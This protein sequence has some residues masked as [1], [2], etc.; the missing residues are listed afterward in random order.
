[1]EFGLSPVQRDVQS[2]ARLS[3][4]PASGMGDSGC[5]AGFEKAF[6]VRN[7]KVILNVLHGYPPNNSDGP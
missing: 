4:L 2:I 7:T 6:G 3:E 1:M 5:G